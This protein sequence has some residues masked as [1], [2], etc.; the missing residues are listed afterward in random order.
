MSVRPRATPLVLMLCLVG[1]SRYPTAGAQTADC[2][3][4]DCHTTVRAGQFLH[5]PT[6]L[7]KC[8][9]CHRPTEGRHTFALQAPKQ[10]LCVQCHTQ[11]ERTYVHR[12]VGQGD[13]TECHNPHGS[14]QRYILR[15]DPDGPLCW[16]CHERDLFQERKFPHAPAA[17]GACLVCHEAHSA[18]HAGLLVESS[19]TLCV[20]CHGDVA[21]RLEISRHA[22]PP[23]ANNECVL[24][25]APHA[26]DFPYH[27]RAQP[28]ELCSS[29]HSQV[30]GGHDAHRVH[31][32]LETEESC[33]ACHRGHGGALPKLLARPPLDECLSCHDE[34]MQAA[35]GE[36]LTDM[37]ALLQNN[38]NHHGPIRQADCS[39]CHNPHASDQ[40]RLLVKEYPPD[41][42]APFDLK[43][44]ALC[45]TCHLQELVTAP[46]GPGVTGFRDG[47]RNLHYVHVNNEKKGRTCRACHEVHASRRPFHIRDK[48][49]Y[50]AGG[51][52]IEINFEA[53][54]E[55]GRCAPGCH[56]PKTYNRSPR[57]SAAARPLKPDGTP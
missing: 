19:A 53:A 31:G 28:R 16:R 52:E 6:A 5:A 18:W 14:D 44:Y 27:L 7:R 33:I 43:Y 17:A 56:E 24:C 25:H 1:A 40:F 50:G 39:A 46:A 15:D 57:G 42:Y 3:T 38:P 10:E 54:P 2:V 48:V 36:R 23:A 9:A 22:H 55:G 29:C 51:W 47:E 4:A 20:R 37:A 32:A 13:C 11:A 35:G 34:P 21:E 8:D 41:F 26:S 45:F 49:P 30:I 12:P